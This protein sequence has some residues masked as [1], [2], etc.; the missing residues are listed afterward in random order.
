MRHSAVAALAE[1]DEAEIAEALDELSPAERRALDEHWPAWVHEGQLPTD[2]PRAASGQAWRVWV[3]LAGRGFGKTRAGAEWV[4]EFARSHPGSS[5]A[6][7]AAT[8]DEARSVMVEGARSGLLAVARHDEREAMVW[9]PSR[10]RLAFASGAEAFVYSAANPESLR[11]PEHHIAWCDELA[12]WKKGEAAWNNLQLGLR[13]GTSPRA[14]VTTTPR[15]VPALKR[16]LAGAGTVRTGGPSWANAQLS[17]GALD[18][19]IAEHGGTRFGRQELEGALIEDVEGTLWPRALIEK[20]RVAG[21]RG[22]SRFAPGGSGPGA[23]ARESDCPLGVRGDSHFAPGGSGSGAAARESD[24]PLRVR[25]DSHFAPGGAGPGGAARESDCPS[26]RP[27]VRIVVG[28]DPPAGRDGDACGIVVCG[29]DAAG[30]GYV[31]ADAS[32]AGL[33]PDGWARRVAAAAGAWGA[34]RVVAE[35][36]IGGDMVAAVLQG[37]DAGLPV[38]LVHAADGKSARAEPVAVRF[39]NGKAKFAGRFPELED[40]LAGFTYAGYVGAGSPDRADAM[41]WA[42]TEL[43]V[44]RPRAEPR[45]LTL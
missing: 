34:D 1:L 44:R 26:S 11:G 3:L 21:V 12:K 10:R 31:L 18:A 7:V 42:M 6:L 2:D 17:P 32:V 28:V 9:E 23:A 39:E 30:V 35:K 36:N 25:G 13:L 4:S 45:I 41:I 37:A 8:A 24:C 22:D 16:I 19:L 15:G 38:T 33:S 29:V 43:I 5:I 27:F 14:L 20:C 40:E